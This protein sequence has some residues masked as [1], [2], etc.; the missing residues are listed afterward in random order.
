[1]PLDGLRDGRNNNVVVYLGQDDREWVTLTKRLEAPSSLGRGELAERVYMIF[2]SGDGNV[3]QPHAT[4]KGEA[5]RS[6]KAM[7]Q[8]R[9]IDNI[10]GCRYFYLQR[11]SCSLD[12]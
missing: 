7:R 4:S 8:P 12:V 3:T 5:G 9:Q 2:L 1:M 6:S 10:A 11:S